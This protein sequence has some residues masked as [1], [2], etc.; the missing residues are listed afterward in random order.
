VTG[1]HLSLGLGAAAVVATVVGLF[2]WEARGL[3]PDRPL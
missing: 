3:R 1:I 2:A